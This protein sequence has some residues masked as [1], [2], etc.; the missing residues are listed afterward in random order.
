MIHLECQI[1]HVEVSTICKRDQ[2]DWFRFN[3]QHKLICSCE[4]AIQFRFSRILSENWQSYFIFWEWFEPLWWGICDAAAEKGALVSDLQKVCLPVKM[5]L[6]PFCLLDWCVGSVITVPVSKWPFL[7]HLH[8]YG[9]VRIPVFVGWSQSSGMG[10]NSDFQVVIFT[11]RHFADASGWSPVTLDDTFTLLPDLYS[12]P[13]P[14]KPWRYAC[15]DNKVGS[16]F[17]TR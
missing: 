9:Q 5:A 6:V 7:L 3:F 14:D 15:S 11:N 10:T 13:G 4:T 17:P 1:C 8:Q 2:P 16:V 12:H